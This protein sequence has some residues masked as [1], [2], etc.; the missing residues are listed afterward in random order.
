[1]NSGCTH[2]R[3]ESWH[4]FLTLRLGSRVLTLTMGE[5]TLKSVIHRMSARLS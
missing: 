2:S 1:M 4:Y 3:F 5:K